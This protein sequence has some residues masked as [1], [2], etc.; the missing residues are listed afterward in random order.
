MRRVR[1]FR[2]QSLL[3]ITVALLIPVLHVH[4]EECKKAEKDPEAWQKSIVFGFNITSGNSDT[5][6]TTAGAKAQREKD[7]NIWQFEGYHSVGEEDNETTVDFSNAL[8]SYKRLFTERFYGTMGTTYIRND[9]SD[10]KY[11]VT[12]DPGLGYF[13]WKEDDLKFSV[14]AGPSYLWE[15]VDGESDDYLAPRVGERIEY[16]L[17]ET[18]KFFEQANV[19]L[20]INDSDNYLVTG[21]AGIEAKLNSMLS[22]VISIKD[23]Y[24]NMPAAGRKQNDLISLTTLSVNF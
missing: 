7:G 23:I 19:L 22:L 24:D 6:L 9:I 15:E 1:N 2:L 3:A 10:V 12:A 17:G 13:L 11:R 18:S 14:E 21:E 4:S 16:A 20:D 5:N 8:A